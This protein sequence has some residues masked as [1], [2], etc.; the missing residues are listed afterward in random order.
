MKVEFPAVANRLGLQPRPVVFQIIA[1][2]T[3]LESSMP[4]IK[5]RTFGHTAAALIEFDSTAAARAAAWDSAQTNEDVYAAEQA[6][7]DALGK[8]QV[9]F[10]KDTA[11]INSLS[12][13]MRVD[14]AFMRRMAANS[15]PGMAASPDQELAAHEEPN[16]ADDS[17]SAP[18]PR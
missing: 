4:Q 18:A 13:C 5:P 7:H 11:D 15:V 2:T 1:A 14:L 10:H 9:A 17:D 12:N 6:D 3:Y 16:D 8:V